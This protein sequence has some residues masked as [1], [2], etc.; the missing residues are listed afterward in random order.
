MYPAMT[1]SMR[2]STVRAFDRTAVRDDHGTYVVATSFENW[3]DPLGLGRGDLQRVGRS[4]VREAA[5][6]ELG[7][8]ARRG[9]HAADLVAAVEVVRPL[10]RDVLRRV[11]ANEEQGRRDHRRVLRVRAARRYPSNGRVVRDDGRLAAC[12]PA[13][14]LPATRRIVDVGQGL[15]V[16]DQSRR[17][18]H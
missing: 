11:L 10:Q 15:A 2:K 13:F 1:R 3:A 7:L 16:E 17:D 4:G 8:C 5:G 18:G 12:G 9:A 14:V 6:P